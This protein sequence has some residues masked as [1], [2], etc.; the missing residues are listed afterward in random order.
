MSFEDAISAANG[1]ALPLQQQPRRLAVKDDS[2]I[3]ASTRSTVQEIFISALY[4]KSIVRSQQELLKFD[5]ELILLNQSESLA[6]LVG[7]AR[8]NIIDTK[9]GVLDYTLSKPGL[10]FSLGDFD[11]DIVSAQWHPASASNTVLVV[12]LK[13]GR[14]L[15]YDVMYSRT[16]PL[17]SVQLEVSSAPTSMVFG[18]SSNLA[19]SLTLYICLES[20]A[21]HPIY[22]V[23]TPG[24]SIATTKKQIDNLLQETDAIIRVVEEKFPSAATVNNPLLKP[25]YD[26]WDFVCFLQK[27]AGMGPNVLVN[28]PMEGFNV[29]LQPE[30]TK[31]PAGTNLVSFGDN[32]VAPMFAAVVP[33]KGSIAVL[34]LAQFKPLIMERSIKTKLVPPQEPSAAPAKPVADPKYVKPSK[35]FGFALDQDS[36]SEDESQLEQME[37]RQ[38]YK[39]KLSIYTAQKDC[40]KF[41]SSEFNILSVVGKCSIKVPDITVSSG[42]IRAKSIQKGLVINYKN[43]FVVADVRSWFTQLENRFVRG[44]TRFQADY[45]RL[46]MDQDVQDY[47][48]MSDRFYGS[49]RYLIVMTSEGKL[50]PLQLDK[51]PTKKISLPKEEEISKPDQE[52]DIQ[53]TSSGEL[54]TI[55]KSIQTVPPKVSFLADTFETLSALY[56][57][58]KTVSGIVLALTLFLVQLQLKLKLQQERMELQ[59]KQFNGLSKDNDTIE[60]SVKHNDY[61]ARIQKLIERQEKILSRQKEM[62]ARIV[63]KFDNA[64]LKWQLPLSD[65]ERK[66]FKELNS[67]QSQLAH[68]KDKD[69]FQAEVAQ[70]KER[71]NAIVQQS[72][73]EDSELARSVQKLLINN[74]IP[75]LYLFLVQETKL[76]AAAKAKLQACVKAVDKFIEA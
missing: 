28:T 63:E 17:T 25:L 30:I 53:G 18:S 52:K 7:K 31:L 29:Q 24:L 40:G 68:N 20:G 54:K 13:N 46:T 58:S 11:L 57:H 16:M 26:Q 51:T 71:V 21:V 76:I 45:K 61:Q 55:L 72:K 38:E 60:E 49:G 36:D 5:I 48:P 39:H 8:I 14:L 56:E 6:A 9:E 74:D 44:E 32:P 70:V 12:L 22:P 69:S 23:V 19:G 65:A 37:L 66:W 67:L 47:A 4:P 34:Y 64:R 33:E 41:L 10:A 50:H 27:K 3:I 35:G 43:I 42:L 59:Q 2:T 62:K 1:F 15:I 75:R 73:S